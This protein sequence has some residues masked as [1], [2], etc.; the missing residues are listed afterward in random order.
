MVKNVWGKVC[1]EYTSASTQEPNVHG[2]SRIF[3]RLS[4]CT[5]SFG[6]KALMHLFNARDT[7]ADAHGQ[8]IGECY[9]FGVVDDKDERG[10]MA[11]DESTPVIK[12]T[13]ALRTALPELLVS[14][15]VCI[16]EYTHHGC[17]GVTFV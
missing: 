12:C 13:A 5:R 11:D 17:N 1:D 14:C 15:D 4:S 10:S 16:C 9:A 8:G 2:V 7:S 3:T 6:V